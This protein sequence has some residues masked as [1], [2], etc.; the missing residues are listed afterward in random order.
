MYIQPVGIESDEDVILYRFYGWTVVR[1][2]IG[3]YTRE[4]EEA[5]VYNNVL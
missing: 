2:G 4:I 5:R 1:A 3:R